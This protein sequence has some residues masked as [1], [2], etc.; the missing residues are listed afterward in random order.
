MSQKAGARG[1]VQ[2]EVGVVGH[3]ENS[4]RFQMSRDI[5]FPFLGHASSWQ[6]KSLLRSDRGGESTDNLCVITA[7]QRPLS[8]VT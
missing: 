1:A 5:S 4:P 7:N 2:E 3:G 8:H 6:A